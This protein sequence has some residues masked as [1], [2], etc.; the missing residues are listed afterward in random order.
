MQNKVL[1][2]DDEPANLI[3]FRRQFRD[4]LDVKTASTANEALEI[5]ESEE[6]PV[7]LT[8][9]KMPG[10]SGSELVAQARR[11]HPDVVRMVVT[12]YSDLDA[13]IRSINEGHVA[14][15][16][17]K[18]WEVNELRSIL[19]AACELYW[20]SRQN[21][22]LTEE[23]LHKKRL[24]AVAA[25]AD[26]LTVELDAIGAVLSPLDRLERTSP[27]ALADLDAAHTAIGR[28]TSII[29]DLRQFSKSSS[30]DIGSVTSADLNDLVA[31]A[32]ELLQLFPAVRALSS[33][34]VELSSERL[35]VEVDPKRL[36]Q[37]LVNLIINLVADRADPGP[38]RMRT[39]GE[40]SRASLRLEGDAVNAGT[41]MLWLRMARRVLED[42][43]GRIRP[44]SEG[45][46]GI[47][48]SLPIR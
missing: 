28:L 21:R 14:R 4:T 13:V 8:D 40:A 39:H 34:E 37:L 3:V 22:V 25:I 36:S 33:F 27:A 47:E 32:L 19:L 42:Y 18:P 35:P 16:V 12:A 2:L 17:K 45:Q 31:R 20:T 1:Y 9:E 43:G 5:L 23:L 26:Q 6:I 10:M 41:A 44:S 24:I 11:R 15:Y 46:A 48:L 29:D 7:L 30:F 38:L